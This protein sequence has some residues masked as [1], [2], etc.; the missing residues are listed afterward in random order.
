MTL[1]LSVAHARELA[2][3]CEHPSRPALVIVGAVAL[4]HHV[5]LPRST[6]DVDLALA[7]DVLEIPALLSGLGWQRDA[8]IPHRW[9]AGHGLL[10]DVLPCTPE[11]LAAGSV[12]FEPGGSEMSLVGF[13]LAMAHGTAEPLADTGAHARVASLEALV[14][15]KM[16]AFLDRPAE[17]TKDLGDLAHV[18]RLALAVDDDRRWDEPL[19]GEGLDFDDQSPFFVGRRVAAVAAPVH[20]RVI[21]EFLRA[22]RDERGTHAAAMARAAGLSGADPAEQAVRLIDAFAR[23][24]GD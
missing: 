13:D 12:R 2:R 1:S 21:A 6:A 5:S 20:R 19:L 15:L 23:G 7:V 24:L 11:L 18:L 22:I 10:A 16:V 9:S 4:A 3:L 8:R 14:V 17:R